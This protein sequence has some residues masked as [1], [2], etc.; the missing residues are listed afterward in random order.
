L[1]HERLE[2]TA[3]YTEPTMHD[4]EEAVRRLKRDHEG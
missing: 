2:T 1:G 3:M 4:L